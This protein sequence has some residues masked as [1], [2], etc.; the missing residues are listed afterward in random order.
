VYDTSIERYAEKAF[1][2]KTPY[3]P[4]D[5]W[6]VSANNIV[7]AHY[8]GEKLSI[9]LDYALY[10]TEEFVGNYNLQTKD[11]LEFKMKI[12][13]LRLSIRGYLIL[14]AGRVIDAKVEK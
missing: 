3:D 8:L 13:Y 10:L 14:K 2:V 6:Y 12:G 9:N 4:N 11:N 1:G 7:S 5:G